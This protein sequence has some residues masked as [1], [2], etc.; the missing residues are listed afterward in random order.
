M[1]VFIIRVPKPNVAI[2]KGKVTSLSKGRTIKL[3][4]PKINPFTITT[5]KVVATGVTPGT[6]WNTTQI[7][8]TL[9]A[10]RVRKALID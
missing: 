4:N 3:T 2:I 9:T 8:T 5:S 10:H 6:N 1:Q 7:A